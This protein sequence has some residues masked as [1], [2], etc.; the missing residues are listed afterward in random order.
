[1]PGIVQTWII[2][3]G[4]V[5]GQSAPPGPPIASSQL[6]I[7][8]RLTGSRASRGLLSPAAAI[9]SAAALMASGVGVGGGTAVIAAPSAAPGRRS[10]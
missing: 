4:A 9:R 8:G 7:I 6:R 3:G 2:A 5:S 1:M 10:R